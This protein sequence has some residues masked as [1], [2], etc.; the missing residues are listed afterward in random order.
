VA[1]LTRWGVAN[2]HVVAEVVSEV[3]SGLDGERPSCVGSL[4]DHSAMVIVVVHR[5][6]LARFGLEY[7]EAVLSAPVRWGAGR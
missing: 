6:W 2:G 7:M 1:R 5:N 4:S 3:G